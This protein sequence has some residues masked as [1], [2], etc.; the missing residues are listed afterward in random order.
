MGDSERV[1]AA[2]IR[3]GVRLTFNRVA[4]TPT[5]AFRFLV[6]ADLARQVG[7]REDVLAGLP[8][9]ASE[10]F[11]G[12]AYLH[13]VLNL[14]RRERV[15]DLGSGGGLDAVLAARAVA[16][17]GVVDGLDLA[18]AM[19]GRARRLAAAV[20]LR[21]VEFTQGD[22][23]AM[24]FVAETFDAAMVNGFFNLCPD[25]RGVAG[26][27]FRV[28]RRGG[29]AAVAEITFTEPLTC[30]ETRTIDDWFR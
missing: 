21:N 22:A 18:E 14:R 13:T 12:L 26:E 9:I 10:S 8:P 19:I 3:E 6:G 20:G 5:A 27:V 24:P 29:R 23:E 25:K 2:E 30:P 11:T 7:Y 15:L 17:G 28:L 4:E 16:P 1:T